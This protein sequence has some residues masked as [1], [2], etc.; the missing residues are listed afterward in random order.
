MKPRPEQPDPWA[1][2]LN[3]AWKEGGP[4]LAL[5]ESYREPP[6]PLRD[7]YASGIAYVIGQRRETIIIQGTKLLNARLTR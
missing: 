3:K 7:E 4:L 5:L 1:R 6:E 2:T